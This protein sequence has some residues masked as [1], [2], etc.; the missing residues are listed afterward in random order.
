MAD[1]CVEWIVWF[2][3]CEISAIARAESR[4]KETRVWKIIILR[5]GSLSRAEIRAHATVCF[6]C[7]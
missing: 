6:V 3:K 7:E 1:R 4:K 5:A 2:R